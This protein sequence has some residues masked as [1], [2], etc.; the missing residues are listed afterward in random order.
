MFAPSCGV[1]GHGP[2]AFHIDGQTSDRSL[3]MTAGQAI[4]TDWAY[5]ISF[6]GWDADELEQHNEAA[7][8]PVGWD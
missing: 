3:F 7:P 8:E 2:L 4:P 5:R 6:V 1:Y